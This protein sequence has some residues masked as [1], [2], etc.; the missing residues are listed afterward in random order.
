M[1]KPK[2]WE[3]TYPRDDGKILLHSCIIEFDS[4]R[5]YEDFKQWCAETFNGYY[6][7]KKDKSR[8]DVFMTI[9]DEQ[10]EEE[11]KA[12]LTTLTAKWH[13]WISSEYWFDWKYRYRLRLKKKSDFVLVKTMWG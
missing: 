8:E 7:L 12:V 3:S 11:R 2:K 1:K 10:Q 13:Y 6:A 9:K 4:L 5:K